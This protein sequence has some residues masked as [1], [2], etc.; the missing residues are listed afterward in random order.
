MKLLKEVFGRIFILWAFIIFAST[1]FIALLFYT[2]CFVLSELQKANWH[3][4]VSRFWM[5]IFLNLIGCPLKIKGAAYF[6]NLP[7]AVIVCN[8]SSLMDVPIT[9]PFMPRA[10]KT[11]AKK[12]ISR[13]P[14]FGWIYSL[15]HSFLYRRLSSIRFLLHR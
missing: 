13:T 8:H 4:S 14:I 15:G 9:T 6:N 12:S 11:I 7:N 1:M 10:N 3:R 2:R 5:T